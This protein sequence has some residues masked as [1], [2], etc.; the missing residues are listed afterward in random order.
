MPIYSYK[1]IKETDCSFN[2]TIQSVNDKKLSK[3]PECGK[4]IEFVLSNT[5]KPVF[6]GSGFYETDYK[7]K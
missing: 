4:K 1:H 2:E 6:K 3:C 7:G 5:S